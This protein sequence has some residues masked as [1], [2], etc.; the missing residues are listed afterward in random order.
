MTVFG[1]AMYSY[2]ALMLLQ[3]IFDQPLVG[4]VALTIVAINILIPST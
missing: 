1:A 3:R 2:L 4:I